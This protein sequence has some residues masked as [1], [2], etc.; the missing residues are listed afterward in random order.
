[1]KET[2]TERLLGRRLGEE[3][4]EE[5]SPVLD[6][7]NESLSSKSPETKEAG[8]VAAKLYDALG[9]VIANESSSMNPGVLEILLEAT[10]HHDTWREKGWL[11]A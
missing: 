3:L 2:P 9:V 5:P 6:K 10:G 4:P 8:A 1:M 7:I 11:K